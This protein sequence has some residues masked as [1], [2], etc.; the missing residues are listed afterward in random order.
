MEDALDRWSAVLF[1]GEAGAQR[2]EPLLAIW[3]R[4]VGSLRGE[5]AE[6]EVWHATRA[7]WALCDA[8]VD[9]RP[10]CMR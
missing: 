7:D 5:D 4:E 9:G 6:L 3:E 1:G 8:I 10:W 2:M